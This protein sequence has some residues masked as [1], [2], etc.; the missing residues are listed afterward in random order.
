MNGTSGIRPKA[1]HATFAP[2]LMSVLVARSIH[3]RMTASGW[4]R[5]TISSRSFFTSPESTRRPT[6][7]PR[8]SERDRGVQ[9]EAAAPAA[10]RLRKE[11]RF[12][13][14]YPAQKGAFYGG[15]KQRRGRS[16]SPVE[17][18]R[19]HGQPRGAG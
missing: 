7:Q 2:A 15:R 12:T 18:V 3:M 13:G 6:G 9:A 17:R 8:A 19:Q 14:K 4:N 16:D 11:S 5:Q 1:A 10:G